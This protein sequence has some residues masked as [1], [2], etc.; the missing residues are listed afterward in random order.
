[1]WHYRRSLGCSRRRRSTR[2][3]L[4]W[5][6]EG[7]GTRGSRSMKSSFVLRFQNFST[8]RLVRAGSSYQWRGPFIPIRRS[9]QWYKALAIG[10]LSKETR[11]DRPAQLSSATAPY[12]PPVVLQE[13]SS[14]IEKSPFCGGIHCQ[15]L[16]S[17][18]PRKRFATF[19]EIGNVRKIQRLCVDSFNSAF[20]AT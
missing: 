16:E 3:A 9:P 15:R 2:T 1:M 6:M 10:D 14:G 7:S 11:N 8:V 18:Y 17:S 20:N 13:F 12:T 5:I 4:V 19:P